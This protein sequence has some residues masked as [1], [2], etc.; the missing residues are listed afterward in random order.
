MSHVLTAPL[1][2]FNE[3]YKLGGFQAQISKPPSQIGCGAAAAMPEAKP[4]AAFPGPALS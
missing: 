1:G 2:V 4:R 3:L